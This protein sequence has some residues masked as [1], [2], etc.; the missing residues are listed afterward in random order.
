MRLKLVALL[1]IDALKVGARIIFMLAMYALGLPRS[2][3]SETAEHTKSMP[4]ATQKDR[5]QP[6]HP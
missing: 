3:L 4:E 6:F 2:R 5:R 1:V